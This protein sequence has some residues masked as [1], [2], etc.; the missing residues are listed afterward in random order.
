MYDLSQ[1]S[2]YAFEEFGD[3]LDH[4]GNMDQSPYE[5]WRGSTC[6]HPGPVLSTYMVE[7]L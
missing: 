6:H 4:V 1:K 3:S 7:R 2:G 5:H